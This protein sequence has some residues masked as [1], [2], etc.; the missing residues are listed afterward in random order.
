MTDQ[1]ESCLLFGLHGH[2]DL[3]ENL[4]VW[5]K[6]YDVRRRH[7]ALRGRKPNEVLKEKLESR[8]TFPEVV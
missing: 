4:A 7:S 2:V 3:R 5:E 1:V 8:E 6:F